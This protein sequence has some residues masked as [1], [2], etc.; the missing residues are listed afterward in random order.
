MNESRPVRV[1]RGR[2]KGWDAVWMERPPLA[3]A[4]V[5]Q[6]GGRVMGMAWNDHQ[7]A[8][9][10]P[11]LEGRTEDVAGAT[12]VRARKRELGFAL[13][14]GDKTWLAPQSRWTDALPFL[15]LDAGAY[16][17]A[18]EAEGPD[19]AVVSMTS[20]ICRETG[21][22]I[23][24]TIRMDSGSP[25]W[26]VVHRLENA[27]HREVEWGPWGVAMV[28][29]PGRAY[30]PTRPDS[31]CPGG[32]MTFAEEGDSVAA[33]EHVVSRLG[34][35]AV[36]ACTELVQFK[37]GTESPEGWVVAIL[38]SPGDRLTGYRKRVNAGP[39]ARFGHGCSAEVFNSAS[40]PYLEMEVH[41]PLARIA[42]GATV[43]IEERQAVFD[44][45]RW[46]E[47]E[48]EVRSHLAAAV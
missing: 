37:F 27:S 38:E 4:L 31:A 1:R 23:R 3:L 40:H 44:V 21:V 20:P 11:A 6:V 30:L 5:P 13:W 43:E 15:D 2:F 29:R 35:I 22:R 8:F 18:I 42:P 28:N 41:G 14:G 46:P 19:K 16:A 48:D 34:A 47:S 36:I 10:M 12:D 33:R 7:L 26:T 25:G 39:G 17:S 9:T 32:L 45:A 24:R